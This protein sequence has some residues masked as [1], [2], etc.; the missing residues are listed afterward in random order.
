MRGLL[1]RRSLSFD[2]G[3]LLSPARAI[4]TAFMRFPIDAVFL[5]RDRFVLHIAHDLDRWRVA[6]GHGAKAVLELPAGTARLRGLELGD[7]LLFVSRDDAVAR[8]SEPVLPPRNI[9]E[10]ELAGFVDPQGR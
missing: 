4:H 9:S 6:S 1:G 3:L 5:D 2:Q 7:R 10:T 8:E